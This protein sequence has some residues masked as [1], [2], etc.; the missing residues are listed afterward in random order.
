VFHANAGHLGLNLPQN[1]RRATPGA[2]VQGGHSVRF[3]SGA[4]G[5]GVFL[6]CSPSHISFYSL[7]FLVPEKLNFFW[8]SS[9]QYDPLVAS[10]SLRRINGHLPAHGRLCGHSMRCVSSAPFLPISTPHL[11]YL[12]LVL[13]WITI[14]SV[15]RRIG[16]STHRNPI[17]ARKCSYL[18]A[19]LG[20]CMV[21]GSESVCC[22]RVSVRG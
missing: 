15:P 22:G 18:D 10:T 1:A 7:L 14:P 21:R 13:S 12:S 2:E 4:D 17:W 5:A 8:D 3:A 20:N 16:C 6:C 19:R 11:L 9:V